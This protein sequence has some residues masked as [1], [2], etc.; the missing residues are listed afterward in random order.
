MTKVK[1]EWLR[2]GQLVP[3]YLMASYLYYHRN[4]SLMSDADYDKLC[5]ALFILWNEPEVRTHQHRHLV[6]R[7]ALAAGTGY[8]I[9]E[10]RYPL[11]VR[12]AAF[13]L[14]AKCGLLP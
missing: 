1:L 11:R 12:G 5:E 4:V 14:A 10:N 9:P 3:C 8:Y 7:D 13:N 6:K 2:T